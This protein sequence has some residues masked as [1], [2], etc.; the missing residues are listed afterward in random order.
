M[1]NL[2]VGDEILRRGL[3]RKA[4]RGNL[5][6]STYD[7]TVGEI[8]AV[9]PE[10]VKAREQSAPQRHFLGPGEMI[11]VLSSEEFHL[12][13]NVTGVATLRTSLTKEG[14]LALNVGII[15]PFFQGPISTVLLNFSNKTFPL[16]V[17]DKFFRVIFIEHEDVQEFR[18]KSDEST[19]RF[20]YIK[21]LE[22]KAHSSFSTSYLNVPRLDNKFYYKS[23]WS[24]LG[25]GLTGGIYGYIAIICL[26]IL[27]WFLFAGTSFPTFFAEKWAYLKG[28]LLP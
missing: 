23:F 11:F 20:G 1:T 5:K 25:Y 7:L 14:L 12:P 10:H 13:A 28:L 9:G 19:D 21:D 22:E 24:L 26:G 15:D 8:V 16:Y 27:I 4:S 18:P 17:G 6:N 3:L 2:I